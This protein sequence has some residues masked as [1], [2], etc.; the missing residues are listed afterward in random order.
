MGREYQVL[1]ALEPLYNLIPKAVAICQDTKVLGDQFYLMERLQGVILRHQLPQALKESPELMK[2]ISTQAVNNLALLHSLPLS[3]DLR[4]LGKPEG[5][6]RRQIEGW[7]KRYK[8]CANTTVNG[9][10]Q[11][12]EWLPDHVPEDQ[13]AF[14]HNDYKYDNLMLDGQT[15]SIIAVLDWEMAT[16]GHPLMDLGTT[17]AYWAESQDHPALQPFSLTGHPGNLNRQQVAEHY[18]EQ[19]QQNLPDIFA[20]LCI[21]LF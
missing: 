14:I 11:A 7:S 17:L 12:M 20:A 19:R 4:A 18:F 9:M 10:E 2:R 15:W 16:V 21:W 1:K 8:N 5:Y 13:E 6:A 3:D